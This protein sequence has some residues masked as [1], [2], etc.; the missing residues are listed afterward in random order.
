MRLALSILVL[1]CALSGQRPDLPFTRAEQSGFTET[2]RLADVQQFLEEVLALDGAESFERSTF[3]NSK[4]GRPLELV[5]VP[6]LGDTDNPLRV[7]VLANIHGGEVCGKEA[8]Q[9]ML[10]ELAMGEHGEIRQGVELW[11][12]PIYNVDGNER[13][14]TT[15]R[16][17]VNGPVGGLGE[18]ANAQS[19]DL[20]R[21][22]VKVAAPETANLLALLNRIDPHV[23]YDLH[24][25]NGAD[26]A[27]HLTYAGSLSPNAPQLLRNYLRDTHFPGLRDR[28]LEDHT[29]RVFDYGNFQGRDRAQYGTF[30]HRPRFATNYVG[31]RNR[32]SILSEAYAYEPFEVR[33]RATR[34]FVLESLRGMQ[35]DRNVVVSLCAKADEQAA[36]G[37]ALFHSDTSLE[38]GRV[39]TVPTRPWD[40]LPVGER[41]TRRLRR[42]EITRVTTRIRVGFTARKRIG[43]PA[44]GWWL[45][46]ETPENVI[47][48]LRLHGLQIQPTAGEIEATVQRFVPTSGDRARRPFQGVRNVTLRGALAEP[49]TTKLGDGFLIPSKQPLSRVAA[50]LL[51][52]ESEDGLATW[53]R[54]FDQTKIASDSEPGSFP[55]LRVN[56]LD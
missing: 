16:S 37:A 27:F 19:F 21:D 29:Y 44:E 34:A 28:C 49:E 26:H 33:V 9:I 17:N 23:F 32:F 8:V 6:A 41:S 53:G 39:G 30:D 14:A 52:P 47:D 50:Q 18:R 48:T 35:A 24:T 25:T 38:E 5:H 42:S 4:E 11:F 55:V 1:S 40:R 54:F 51:E 12:A 15:N 3:G 46:A 13:V 36:S 56:S 31:L 2:S 7:L 20:N 10:R 43:M 45:P 22:F